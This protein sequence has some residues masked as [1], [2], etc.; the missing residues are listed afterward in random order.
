[1]AM[2]N[3]KK[4][5]IAA[6]A[7]AAVLLLG[8]TF[9]WQSISQTALNEASDVVNPG[10]RLHD[11]FYIDSNGEYNSDIYVENFA[12]DDIFARV[13]LE[14]Y[15]EIVMN[16]GLAAETV[17]T[18]VGSKT[19]KEGAT[20]NSDATAANIYDYEYV[21]H[22]F[23]QEN[24]TDKH[25]TWTTGDAESGQVYYMPT[26]NKNKD[27][28]VADRNGMY[29]DRIGG[30]SDRRQE[31]YTDWKE[32]NAGEFD[33][34]EAIYDADRNQNDEVGYDFE[35]LTAYIDE[36]NIIT[37]TENH[38]TKAVGTTNR[39]ISIDDWMTLRDNGEDTSNYW[40]YDTDGSGWVYW[41]SPIEAG[42]STGLLLDKIEL[43]HVM[44]DSWYYAIN[45]VGQ[46][47]TKDDITG[48]YDEQE[49]MAPSD[50]ALDLLEEIGA[51]TD[52]DDVEE[53]D[54]V[55]YQMYMYFYDGVESTANYLIP[56]KTYAVSV[57]AEQNDYN[58]TSVSL[59]LAKEDGTELTAGEDY[60]VDTA[61]KFEDYTKDD[62][63]G[64]AKEAIINL[65]IL[66]EN[67]VGE[68]IT[69]T[70]KTDV[71]GNAVTE[72]TSVNYEQI[73]VSIA[74]YDSYGNKVA[75]NEEGSTLAP[76]STYD[77]VGT[78]TGTNGTE[79]VIYSTLA[80]E[81]VPNNI[82][83]PACDVVAHAGEY[84]ES[85]YINEEGKLVVGDAETFDC[86][87]WMDD[88]ITNLDGLTLAV[89]ADV[90]RI[91]DSKD[92]KN[93]GSEPSEIYYTYGQWDL[94]PTGQEQYTISIIEEINV[95]DGFEFESV[96]IY[97]GNDRDITDNDGLKVTVSG[98][99]D[100]GTKI[101]LVG[102]TENTGAYYKL[103]LGK[104]ENAKQ[105]I[106]TATDDTGSASKTVTIKYNVE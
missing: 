101:V 38:E 34:A 32:W 76:N 49:G 28:L 24:K 25:W 8:G 70:A 35:N 104:D 77:I 4:K 50:A 91:Y 41:T 80:D 22:Y 57:C 54:E 46:F 56:G 10:G 6:V 55:Y 94:F 88:G 73:D 93:N 11:D 90:V 16:K 79:Y 103:T 102:E 26:F 14:E 59:T 53:P 65:K 71:S 72:T 61:A 75:G 96:N 17:E 2:N 105:L 92:A 84:H 23:D 97:D 47:V 82:E 78:I 60:E 64:Y 37:K 39:L 44:D 74:L 7:T 27:S 15:M 30:I 98:N 83:V 62:G 69:V 68:Y 18:V 21:P 3:K 29:V 12:D 85:N 66:N 51:V 48:F 31:Q 20:A 40:V 33:E 106:I 100:P 81:P 43:N 99:S 1:M 13:K 42:E 52:E 9:A 87:E 19:L 63:N 95:S 86:D 58:D 45:A 67:L 89:G 5:T 36:D